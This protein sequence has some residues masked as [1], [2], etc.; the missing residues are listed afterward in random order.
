MTLLV[1]VG[2]V[3]GWLWMHDEADASQLSGKWR[4]TDGVYALE[5]NQP[6]TNGSINAAYFNPHPIHVEQAQWHRQDDGRLGISIKLQ[7][8]GYPGSTYTLEYDKHQ[9][10]LHGVYF[11]AGLHE[12]FVVEFRR[13]L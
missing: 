2:I 11:H 5:L 13:R 4:R 10:K 1:T 7:D 9:D 12:S 3:G 6:E 8:V